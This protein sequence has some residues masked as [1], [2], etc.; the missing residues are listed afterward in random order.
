[1]NPQIIA[2]ANQKGGVGK[3]TT[4]ANLGIGLALA[5]KKV[6]LVDADPQASLTISLVNP[7]PDKLPFTLSDAMGR[8]LMDEPLRPG[9]GILDHSE[10]VDLMPAD[11]HMNVAAVVMPVRVG[12]Y[13]GLVAGEMLGAK[14][15]AQFLRPVYG[16]A[17][18]RAV[19]WVKADD[20][21]VLFSHLKKYR[22]KG[23]KNRVRETGKQCLVGPTEAKPG[24]F[25]GA[26]IPGCLLR[27]LPPSPLEQ[28]HF[29]AGCAF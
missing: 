5:G 13:K 4:C 14:L 3:T 6:L 17:I 22:P 1:M 29:G 11:M 21:S 26:K 25:A 18:V 15:L 9:E 7:Q 20:I 24:I 16:Q 8:I 27:A 28:L 12:A 2:I 23:H 10:G 19:P